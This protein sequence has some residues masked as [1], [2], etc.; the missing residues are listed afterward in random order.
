MKDLYYPAIFT[1][2]EEG[3][4]VD[5]PDIDGCSTQGDD[6]QD[7]F[8]MA[9][10]ALGLVLSVLDDENRELPLPTNPAD[11]KLEEGQ[12]VAVIRFNM[13]E[14]RRKTDN[15][16]VK[17]TLTIPSWM[18]NKALDKQINFSQLLQDALMQELGM[19]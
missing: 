17:K 19:D 15:H 3:Y 4:V 18:N 1:K 13:L 10:D 6:L 9:H 11:F 7:A 16:A 14:Y 5:F 2:D 12:F 8:Y